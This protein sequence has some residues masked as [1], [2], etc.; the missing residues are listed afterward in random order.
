M[1]N[2]DYSFNFIF[3]KVLRFLQMKQYSLKK[4]DLSNV[5]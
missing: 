1:K 4:L 3:E 2:V 5:S